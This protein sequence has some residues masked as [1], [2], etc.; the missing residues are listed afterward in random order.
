MIG[1][2]L[3]SIY[4]RFAVL[5]VDEITESDPIPTTTITETK[6][7]PPLP[8][9][10]Q[11]PRHPKWEKRLPEQYVIA[12]TPSSKSLELPILMQTT[13]TGT[14]LSTKGLLDCGT[15]NLFIHS[16]FV[17]RNKLTT[18]KLSGLFQYIMW[19]EC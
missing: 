12:T 19:M 18:K 9:H 4:N 13:D 2:P 15:T 6:A 16:D 3:L 14:I 1:V 8:C 17:Q 7:T 5:P 11:L 10:S